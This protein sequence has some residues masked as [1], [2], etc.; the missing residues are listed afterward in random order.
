MIDGIKPLA[1]TS[2]SDGIVEQLTVLIARGT[3]KPGERMPSEKLLCE[4][5]GVGRTSVREALKSLA[6]MGLIESQAGEGHFVATDGS[7]AVDRALQVGMLLDA[8][9][10]R[11]LIETRLMLESEAAALAARRATKEHVAAIERQLEA[12]EQ[13]GEDYAQYLEADLRFH[14]AIAAA[15]QNSILANLLASIRGY[16]QSWVHEALR[17]GTRRRA[18]GSIA[19][20]RRIADA[21]RKKKPKAA[22]QAMTDHI[23]SSS[24][25][26]EKTA[27]AAS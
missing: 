8:T 23:L 7:R 14:L 1:R 25:D 27:R 24:A 15:S 19:E 13:A 16:L 18:E 21:I 6:A 26:L 9:K 5:F 3:L 10:V 20:H 17:R 11:E 2:L 4:Q 12:M 22:R